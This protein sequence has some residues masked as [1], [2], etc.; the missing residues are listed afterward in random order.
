[1][2][3]N[4]LVAPFRLPERVVIG[5]SGGGDST[6]LLVLATDWARNSGREIVA[7]TVNHGIRPESRLEC[8]HVARLCSSLNVVHRTLEVTQEAPGTGLQEWARVQ[9][10]SLLA[11]LSTDVGGVPV[12]LAHTQDDQAETVLMRLLRGAGVDGL[13]AMRADTWHGELRIIRPLLG[14]TGIRLREMLRE[15]G[16]C[17]IEDPSNTDPR[18]ERVRLRKAMRGLGLDSVALA[19]TASAMGRARHALEAEAGRLL[20]QYASRGALG[21]V[22]LDLRGL[23]ETEEEY[24]VRA[25]AR[26][27]RIV[28]GRRTIR[29][30]HKRLLD[31][32]RWALAPKAQPSGC[33]LAGCILKRAS[34][35]R[36]LVAREP[37][38]CD[39][40]IPL[41]KGQEVVWDQRW[42]VRFD[43]SGFA[44]VGALGYSGARDIAGCAAHWRQS[45]A[46]VRASVP[47]FRR[48]GRIAAIPSVEY[49]LDGNSALAGAELVGTWAG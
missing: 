32:V 39:P 16:Q 37:A 18:F 5:V 13:A 47:A 23:S 20:E 29:F 27:L 10:F 42:R 9:R 15:R 43:G 3:F 49:W 30:R 12:M 31:T 45:P 35:H 2:N 17:W 1:M 36:L 40:P 22:V 11:G 38:M 34:G 4:E 6:A 7:G 48:D 24:A 25:F 46:L 8:E 44:E 14:V 19:R 28:A 41:C 21:E 26:L 33:T